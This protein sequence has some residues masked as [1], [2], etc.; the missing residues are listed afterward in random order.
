MQI[1]LPLLLLHAPLL[2]L[3][4]MSSPPQDPPKPSSKP[5]SFNR[6]IKHSTRAVSYA[7]RQNV[8]GYIWIS[9]PRSTEL[10]VTSLPR[11]STHTQP[12]PP[13]LQDKLVSCSSTRALKPLQLKMMVSATIY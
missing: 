8:N 11:S 9:F 2:T 10:A 7:H 3:V 13:I 6:S 12:S 5:P 4:D 1:S